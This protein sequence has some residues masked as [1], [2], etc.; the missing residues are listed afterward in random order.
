M[1]A[2]LREPLLHFLFLGALLFAVDAWRRPPE[3]V[4]VSGEIVVSEARVRT[5]AQNF[6]RTW[7]RPPTRE[8]L[9]GLVESHV[10]EE[11]MVREALALGLDR[12]DAIIRRRLQQKVEFVSDQAAALTAPSDADLETY[13]AKN[14][15]AFR[16]EPR[17]TFVQV[18]LDAGKRGAAL[19]ADAA[20]LRERL[21][22]GSVDA[23]RA[24]DPLMLLDA[25]YE[26]M[27]QAE[28]ARLFGAEFADEIVKQPP[29]AWVG[30]L[31]SGYGAHLV[32]VEAASPAGMPSLA[33][34]RP[35]VEREWTNAR[36][37]ELAQDWYATLR[38]KYKVSVQMPQPAKP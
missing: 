34:V 17:V 35:L 10:R 38:A 26:D 2:L 24:G 36:R 19:Q 33:E 32:K 18:Y 12:D 3:R 9:D 14:P 16:R 23:A 4:G 1:K 28:V 11:V 30:P 5:L 37:R 6:A 22:A 8:E 21:A 15:D 13:L 27:P 29:G 20:R 31:R 7:Q 25:R